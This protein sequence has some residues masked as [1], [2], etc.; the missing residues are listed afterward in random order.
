[1]EVYDRAHELARALA[2]SEEYRD[3]RLARAK[4]ESSPANL[5]MLQDFR[6]RQL[7]MEMAILNGKEPEKTLRQALEESYR[8]ISLNPSITAYLAAEERLAR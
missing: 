8:I 5:D 3:Y 2:K 1:M 6:R 4:L 7:E